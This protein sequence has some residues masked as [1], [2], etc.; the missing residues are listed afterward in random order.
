MELKDVDI[1]Q[2]IKV[3]KELAQDCENLYAELTGPRQDGR[4]SYMNWSQRCEDQL[5]NFFADPAVA[6]DV[7]TDRY[8]RIAEVTVVDRQPQ[9]IGSEIRVQTERL[10][11]IAATV[12]G[13]LRLRERSG[14]IVLLD[15]NVLLNYQRVDMVPWRRV[16]GEEHVRL[17][18]PILV[19][20]EL[21]DKRY[22]G[23]PDVRERARSAIKPLDE[24]RE[25]FDRQGYATLPD[26]TTLECLLDDPGHRPRA[27]PDEEILDRAVF[28]SRVTKE[29]VVL[30]TGDRGMR[31]RASTRTG[32]RAVEMPAR[33]SRD[34]DEAKE[35]ATGSGGDQSPG[36][37]SCGHP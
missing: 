32:I 1:D 13:Y 10:R 11:T 28:L 35:A 12:E 23:R 34:L 6:Q 17:I 20:D 30:V 27:N 19:V 24:L 25:Q 22:L 26:G 9:V 14:T 29:Q 15:T 2:A 37:T 5:R 36:S 18:L 16:T 31:F 4:G 7:Y 21:D 33:F 3:L 8:W